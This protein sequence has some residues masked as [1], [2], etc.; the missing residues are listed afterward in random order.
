MVG[1]E[2]KEEATESTRELKTSL[3]IARSQSEEAR[4]RGWKH[5]NTH[6]PSLQRPSFLS[7]T[8]QETRPLLSC[9]CS[10]E[11]VAEVCFSQC[12]SNTDGYKSR[13]S[14]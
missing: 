1:E 5:A 10:Y 11:L 6:T 9:V 4:G 14:Q 3:L 2:S 8:Q 7:H 13:L 12:S